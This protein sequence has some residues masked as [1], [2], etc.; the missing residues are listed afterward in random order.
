MLSTVSRRASIA[1]P[2]AV[3]ELSML[4]SR[5][6]STIAGSAIDEARPRS[7]GAHVEE[8]AAIR[9]AG[10]YADERAE[11]PE[12]EERRCGQDVGQGRGNAVPNGT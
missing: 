6:P 10:A 3:A 5:S 7:G 1:G 2:S 12:E 8:G 9:K 11:G 4:D